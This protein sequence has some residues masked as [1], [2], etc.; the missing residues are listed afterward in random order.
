MA[1]VESS[2]MQQFYHQSVVCKENAEIFLVKKSVLIKLIEKYAKHNLW[3]IMIE[4][5]ESNL[6][7]Y[8]KSKQAV[9]FILQWLYENGVCIKSTDIRQYKES[10][11][12]FIDHNMLYN[13]RD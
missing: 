3:D 6:V 8:Y 5:C 7:N 13:F 10:N 9:L 4:I 11:G 2:I 1:H 12:L